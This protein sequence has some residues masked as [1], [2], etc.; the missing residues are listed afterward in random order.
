MTAVGT[1]AWNDGVL[2]TS[3]PNGPVRTWRRAAD[4]A[5]ARL[6][7]E[8]PMASL[9]LADGRALL[10]AAFAVFPFVR[11]PGPASVFGAGV[12]RSARAAFAVL[13]DDAAGALRVLRGEPDEFILFARATREGW[14]VGAVTAEPLVLT[15]RVEDLW[16]SPAQ[17][18]PPCSAFRVEVV[19]DPNAKDTPEAQAAGVVQETLADVGPDARIFLELA[20]GGGFL[21][22]V[23]MEGM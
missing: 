17:M 6:A 3:S 12:T 7:V 8:P 22:T 23:R 13:A 21:L 15:V 18:R 11:A 10:T 19:R 1:L 5:A 16:R 4:L 2:T 9:E 20:R 14:L